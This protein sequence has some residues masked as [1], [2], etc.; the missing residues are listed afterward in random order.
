MSEW[1]EQ[2][3]YEL[4][5]TL[6]EYGEAIIA[7]SDADQDIIDTF[8]DALDTA[9]CILSPRYVADKGEELEADMNSPEAQAFAEEAKNSPKAQE[10]IK[11]ID[12][13]AEGKITLDELKKKWG[14]G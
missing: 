10:F 9:I 6:D 14:I 4:A 11:D 1:T 2:K 7:T 5:R 12:A 13:H 8:W 3:K